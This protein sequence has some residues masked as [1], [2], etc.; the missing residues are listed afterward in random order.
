MMALP[1]IDS[2]VSACLVVI[3]WWLAHEN[4]LHRPFGKVLALGYMVLAAVIIANMA[5]VLALHVF[6]LVIKTALV[7]VFAIVLMRLRR[8]RANRHDDR[9]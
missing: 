5:D 6:A 2:I 9:R 8:I 3:C 7:F 1:F 4:A